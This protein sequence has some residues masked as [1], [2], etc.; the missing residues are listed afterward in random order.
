MLEM[1]RWLFRII[2]WNKLNYTFSS[3]FHYLRHM[4]ENGEK[5]IKKRKEK[6]KEGMA[7]SYSE[8]KGGKLVYHSL[9]YN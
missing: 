5:I 7:H 6:K 2:T 3:F 9:K 8:I 4:I 1:E